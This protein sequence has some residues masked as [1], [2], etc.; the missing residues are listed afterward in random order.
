MVVY[1]SKFGNTEKVARALAKGLVENGVEADVV[2]SDAV[3]LEELGKY[4]LFAVG[5]PVHAWNMT[6]P[7]KEFM[8]RLKAVDGL[9]G[10][11]AFAFDTKLSKSNLAGSAGGKIEGKLKEIGMVIAK[12]HATAVVKGNEGPLEEGAEEAFTRIGAELARIQ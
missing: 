12:P 9:K 2:K 3:K 7:M 11:K 10:K 4:D 1:D 6:K 5:S 8:E